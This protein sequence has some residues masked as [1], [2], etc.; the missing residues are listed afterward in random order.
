VITCHRKRDREGIDAAGVLG[1]FRGVAVHDA[2]VRY[3]SYVNAGHQLPQRE[4]AAVADAAGPEAVWCWATQA[5]DALVAMQKLVADAIDVM[6]SRKAERRNL[7]DD[8]GDR[9]QRR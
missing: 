3:D 5:G 2:W 4:L 9:H 7:L 1:R 8:G 6:T